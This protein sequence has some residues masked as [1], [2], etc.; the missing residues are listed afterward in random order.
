MMLKKTTM[1]VNLSVPVS[2]LYISDSEVIFGNILLM[3]LMAIIEQWNDFAA[4]ASTE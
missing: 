2:K 3:T 1:N 4:G